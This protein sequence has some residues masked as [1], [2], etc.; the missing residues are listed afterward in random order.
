MFRFRFPRFVISEWR[1]R[2]YGRAED[3]GG[4]WECVGLSRCEREW[5][6]NYENPQRSQ[7]MR[8]YFPVLLSVSTLSRHHSASLAFSSSPFGSR[9]FALI[10]SAR[11]WTVLTFRQASSS[12]AYNINTKNA[13][14]FSQRRR[15]RERERESECVADIGAHAMHCTYP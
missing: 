6:V 3:G 5:E 8:E 11:R 2:N 12:T 15:A 10:F 14:A 9:S 7:R 1:S 13:Y 4:G